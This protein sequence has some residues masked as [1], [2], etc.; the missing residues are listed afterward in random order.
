MARIY[1]TDR[2]Q[3]Y[4]VSKA[5]SRLVRAPSVRQTNQDLPRRKSSP[6]TFTSGRGE[7]A[8]ER[9]LRRCTFCG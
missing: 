5:C 2:G 7:N 6:V 8:R 9:K 4:H 1:Y 3:T